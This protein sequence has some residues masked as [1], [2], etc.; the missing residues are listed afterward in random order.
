MQERPIGIRRMTSNADF[1][2]GAEEVNVKFMKSEDR[3]NRGVAVEYDKIKSKFR[4][5]LDVMD[6]HSLNKGTALC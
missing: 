3:K 5:I 2:M 6:G 1:F 4:E